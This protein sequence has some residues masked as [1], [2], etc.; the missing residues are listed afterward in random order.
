MII[1]PVHA[2]NFVSIPPPLSEGFL[3][4][5]SR[6]LN[7]AWSVAP[8][9]AC[10]SQTAP[11]PACCLQR[12]SQD[13]CSDDGKRRGPSTPAPTSLSSPLGFIPRHFQAIGMGGTTIKI[14]LKEKHKKGGNRT[15][16]PCADGVVLQTCNP[17]TGKPEA[18][19]LPQVRD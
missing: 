8:A 13:P 18:G 1:P 10:P 15:L 3:V 14:I 19:G 2:P 16:L 7:A 9:V 17:S 11:H 4:S 12:H 6:L 5:I